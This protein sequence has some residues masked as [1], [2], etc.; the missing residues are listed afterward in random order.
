[1]K[2]LVICLIGLSTG[3]VGAQESTNTAAVA[4]AKPIVSDDAALM[5]PALASVPMPS[6][7]MLGDPLIHDAVAAT[8]KEEQ[9]SGGV[10]F[11]RDHAP[12]YAHNPAVDTPRP[13][14]YEAFAIAFDQAKL[15]DCLHADGL[16]YQPVPP[17]VPQQF[18]LPFIL[19][20]R[21]RGVCI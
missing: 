2:R 21:L 17:L 11:G 9:T 10:A 16:R 7:A 19:V 5:T 20:A 3:A 18:L 4:V 12:A 14:K 8:L 15:P 13:G 1:M 6:A